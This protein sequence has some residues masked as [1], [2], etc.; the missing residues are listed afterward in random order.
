MSRSAEPGVN[1]KPRQKGG[2]ITAITSALTA[3][4]GLPA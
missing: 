2:W 4:A 1:T 3:L